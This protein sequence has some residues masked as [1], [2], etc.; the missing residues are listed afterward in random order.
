M[1]NQ[2]P[3][4]L[5]ED[6]QADHH[7]GPYPTVIRPGPVDLTSCPSRHL[8]LSTV[9]AF[10]MDSLFSPT[11]HGRATSF[12]EKAHV[13]LSSL[14]PQGP[15]PSGPSNLPSLGLLA[16]FISP[17]SELSCALPAVSSHRMPF[18]PLPPL[19]LTRLLGVRGGLTLEYHLLPKRLLRLIPVPPPHPP[20]D[21]VLRHFPFT[22]PSAGRRVGG[23]LQLRFSCPLDCGLHKDRTLLVLPPW[24][25]QSLSP[26]HLL[27]KA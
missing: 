22:V 13:L 10:H 3:W 27:N 18:Y 5:Q 21:W 12:E 16:S 24:C 14:G 25:S 9:A 1:K 11:V 19:S 26:T 17:N 23:N 15:A 2:S 6:L 7:S 4:V 20:L 8:Q